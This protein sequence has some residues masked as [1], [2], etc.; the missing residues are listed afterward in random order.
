L[1]RCIF[2]KRG[3]IEPTIAKG[4]IFM[5]QFVK[6]QRGIIHLILVVLI[7]SGFAV[8][9]V[10]YR[11]IQYKKEQADRQAA[12]TAQST[13]NSAKVNLDSSQKTEL[14][15]VDT[16]PPSLTVNPPSTSSTKPSPTP[17]PTSPA[18]A[19]DGTV[20]ISSDGCIV[21]AKG[22]PGLKLT[23]G[24]YKT[25]GGG[26]QDYTI[27]AS[28]IITVA[29]G[30]FKGMTGFGDLYNSSNTKIGSASAPITATQ[31]APSGQI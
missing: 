11:F 7:I 15:S 22:K 19:P 6:D 21:T 24:A 23:A 8:A 2:I 31:C 10:S 30:G 5:S 17:S 16:T 13:R 28:G 20:S 12:V 18:P 27:P 25:N 14:E 4:K 9:G 3:I 26:S 29:T 1:T